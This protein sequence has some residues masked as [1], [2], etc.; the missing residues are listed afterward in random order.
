MS[1]FKLMFLKSLY[2]KNFKRFDELKI[3]FPDD[4]TV[5]IGPNEKGKSTLVS[6]IIAGL[7][8]D[9][10]K[11]NREIEVLRSWQSPDKFYEIKM[12][13]EANGENCVL[14]K[15]FERKKIFFENQ[16]TGEKSDDFQEIT[17]KFR[18]IG[19][20][21]NAKLFESTSCVRQEQIAS[22]AVEKKELG[23]ALEDLIGGGFGSRGFGEIIQR[24]EKAVADLNR[25]RG[26]SGW[27]IAKNPGLIKSLE[28]KIGKNAETRLAAEE[29]LKKV[30]DA[31]LNFW[32]LEG[33]FEK[34][35]KDIELSKKEL[36]NIRT[37]TS[38]RKE[39]ADAKVKLEEI[40]GDLREI[41]GLRKKISQLD[42]YLEKLEPYRAVDYNEFLNVLHSI[43]VR[44]ERLEELRERREILRSQG[45]K[46]KEF[47]NPLLIY[48]MLPLT[49]AGALGFF[50]SPWFFFAWILEGI[51]LLW[52]AFSH[53]TLKR[54]TDAELQNQIVGLEKELTEIKKQLANKF[55]AYNV[56]SFEELEE[57]KQYLAQFEKEKH[58]LESK[59]EGIL[60]NQTAETLKAKQ[61]E[62]AGRLLVDE[63]KIERIQLTREPENRDVIALENRLE[64]SAKEKEKLQKEMIETKAVISQTRVS[65]DDIFNLEAQMG[66]LERK[67]QKAFEKEKVYKL[68]AEVLSQAKKE[69]EKDSRG[70]LEKYMREFLAE[71]TDGRYRQISITDDWLLK[72]FSPEKGEEI[73]PDGQ[74]SQGTIDQFYL[75]ARFAFLKLLFPQARP[76][77]ILDDPFQSF[78]KKRRQKT[79]K[80][81]KELSREF[82]ILLL[83]HSDDYNDWGTVKKL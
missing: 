22:V 51:L 60:R 26:E 17:E 53:R 27:R 59:I 81:L 14:L 33:D 25:G 77:I 62:L 9:P 70:V 7:F 11:R 58:L 61:H 82:Q 40:S 13:F 30:Q 28:D 21:R 52:F 54:L 57:A 1:K 67:L 48:L 24:L 31:W 78:D 83:T 50:F 12:E 39:M 43:K 29:A 72:V 37:Y 23:R 4:I 56:E 2:L 6:A 20:Y 19:G 36:E 47:I 42:A 69:T 49:A 71:I 16:A 76:L 15:D 18:Q 80:I 3:D 63:A 46:T 5:V 41:E 10:K 55:E 34:I 45:K 66:Q 73:L 74:L 38:L 79:K 44:E 32:R 35:S 68:T 8:Y 65:E 75:V 64:N